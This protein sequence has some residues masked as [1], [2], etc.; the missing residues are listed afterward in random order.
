MI[1][2][3]QLTYMTTTATTPSPAA[4]ARLPRR[5]TRVSGATDI[6]IRL[7]GRNDI[8]AVRELEE[9]DGRALTDGPRLVAS[10]GGVPVAALSVLD[11][12]VVAD[13][14]EKTASVVDLLRV[15]ARQ[16]RIAA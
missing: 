8:H 3:T 13:P 5:R 10:V 1:A 2:P 7:A 12:A 11:D 6:S 16:L 9:L 14:F 15:R 4:L